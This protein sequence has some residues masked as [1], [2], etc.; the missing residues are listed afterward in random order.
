M[1]DGGRHNEEGS[2][3][4]GACSTFAESGSIDDAAW[5]C[6]NSLVVLLSTTWTAGESAAA[7][8]DE[9]SASSDASSVMDSAM[10]PDTQS[11]TAI[12]TAGCWAAANVAVTT[13]RREVQKCMHYVAA[14]T[15][16]A[17]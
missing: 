2:E 10:V 6:A 15:V 9:Q 1:P 3:D 11:L 17:S 4:G 12:V 5:V 13:S 16:L 14:M 7:P 8:M